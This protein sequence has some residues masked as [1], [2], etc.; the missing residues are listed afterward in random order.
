MDL[1]RFAS[2]RADR[3]KEVSGKSRDGVVYI[4]N[5]WC[6]PE[7]VYVKVSSCCSNLEL[8]AVSLQPYYLPREFSHVIAVCVYIPTRAD[9]VVACE[10]IHTVTTRLQTQHAESFIIISG[11]FNHVTLDSTLA[12]FHQFVDN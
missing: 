3:D 2:V 5:R 11:D 1:H 10:K 4:N 6:N 12:V 9:A 8:L 7:H